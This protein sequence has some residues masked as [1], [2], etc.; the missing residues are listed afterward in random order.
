[1][2]TEDV[3]TFQ[4]QISCQEFVQIELPKILIYLSLESG[5]ES[6]PLAWTMNGLGGYYWLGCVLSVCY[7]APTRYN[8]VICRYLIGGNLFSVTGLV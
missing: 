3:P 1:M 2:T 7:N 4:M 8:E 5:R 6:P